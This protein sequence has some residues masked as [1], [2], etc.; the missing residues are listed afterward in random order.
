MLWLQHN[1]WH[2]FSS[3]HLQFMPVIDTTDRNLVGS[4]V[5]PAGSMICLMRPTKLIDVCL[6]LMSLCRA[7]TRQRRVQ[8]KMVMCA[9]IS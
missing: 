8:G 9:T 4:K 7:A 1:V 5:Q 3:L 2:S 6:A